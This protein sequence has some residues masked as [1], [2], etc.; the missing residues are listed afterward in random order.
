[1]SSQTPRMLNLDEVAAKSQRVLK[2]KGEEYE[3]KVMT[4]NEFITFT[5]EAEEKDA[6]RKESEDK[7]KPIALSEQI[8]ML[9]KMIGNSF[10]TMPE[11]VLDDLSMEQLNVIFEFISDNVEKDNNGKK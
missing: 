1:M 5:K 11:K 4:V 6:L 10:P 7:D 2:I 3:M 9:V 8:E